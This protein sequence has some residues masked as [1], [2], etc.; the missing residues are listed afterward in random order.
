MKRKENE[1]I[2][3]AAN[4]MI[5]PQRLARFTA[6]L[7]RGGISNRALRYF[8][9]MD[10]FPG[11]RPRGDGSRLAVALLLIVVAMLAVGLKP[12]GYRIVNRIDYLPEGK[13]MRL[14]APSVA[15]VKN[16]RPPDPRP[17]SEGE[18][19]LLI[20]LTP[21][22]GHTDDISRIVSFCDGLNAERVIVGQYHAS[23]IV[24]E[25]IDGRKME[26]GCRGVFR[27]G[28]ETALTVSSGAG[29]MRICVD[30][31]E[32]AFRSSRLVLSRFVVFPR[33]IVIG[34][35][36]DGRAPWSGVLAEIRLDGG[37]MSG[38]PAGHAAAGRP[39][40]SPLRSA[41]PG[42]SPILSYDF[43]K[44]HGRGVEDAA[45]SFPDL[46]VP[47]LFTILDRRFLSADWKNWKWNA[48]AISDCFVNLFG[49]M[50]FGFMLAAFLSRRGVSRR[51]VFILIPAAGALFSVAIQSAQV[52]IPTRRTE[53]SDLVLNTLG[54]FCGA[55]VILFL[56]NGLSARSLPHGG[57]AS[58]RSGWIL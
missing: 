1:K 42:G 54:A 18:F 47:R 53:M 43:G 25:R 27:A 37:A 58:S 19:T 55:G 10:S 31:V 34:N 48:D 2:I 29:G 11:H 14:T 13:G 33:T 32:R 36:P 39:C 56:K 7:R 21:S 12:R 35:S 17:A 23:L 50:P 9:G 46:R 20:R 24:Q 8:Y 16:A 5:Q 44:A 40:P 30:G 26:F 45:G 57:K 3:Y 4:K 6:G 22:I 41:A 38:S 51:G 52:I 49:F 28:R 15:Y